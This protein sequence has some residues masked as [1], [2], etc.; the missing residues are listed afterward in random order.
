M[1]STCL[2]SIGI[3]VKVSLH[4]AS[5]QVVSDEFT[6]C[7]LLCSIDW[8]CWLQNSHRQ[9]PFILQN[10]KAPNNNLGMWRGEKMQGMENKETTCT[11][12]DMSDVFWAAPCVCVCTYTLSKICLL[13][14]RFVHA[15]TV[16]ASMILCVI[17]TAARRAVS[18]LAPLTHW[19]LLVSQWS[20]NVLQLYNC[21]ASRLLATDVVVVDD[22]I[23]IL[24]ESPTSSLN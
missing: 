18:K 16:Q 15:H 17:T 23:V 7:S 2:S 21:C 24:I 3:H 14:F 11:E 4:S 8:M 1:Q 5:R 19:G 12:D 22:F 10:V 6:F 13:Y 20:R 9:L